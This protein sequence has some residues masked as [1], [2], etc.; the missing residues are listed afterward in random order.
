MATTEKQIKELEDHF[1]KGKLPAFVQLD[2][3]SK[4]GNVSQFIKSHL[5]VLRNNGD[6]S[7]YEVFYQRLLRLKEITS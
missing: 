5:K 2:L 1:A 6:K 3:G 4:I 7:M